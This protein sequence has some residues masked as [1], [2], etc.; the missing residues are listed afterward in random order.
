MQQQLSHQSPSVSVSKHTPSHIV[1][2]SQVGTEHPRSSYTRSHAPSQVSAQ[3][4]AS[5]ATDRPPE[6]NVPTVPS[7][8]SAIHQTPSARTPSIQKNPTIE[9]VPP[10][11]HSIHSRSISASDSRSTEPEQIRIHPPT[12]SPVNSRSGSVY[13]QSRTPSEGQNYGFSPSVVNAAGQPLPPPSTASASL[14][15]APTQNSRH[16]IQAPPSRHSQSHRSMVSYHEGPSSNLPGVGEEVEAEAEAQIRAQA[17]TPEASRSYVSTSAQTHGAANSSHTPHPPPNAQMASSTP[18]A[19]TTS[20]PPPHQL[21]DMYMYAYAYPTLVP[22]PQVQLH[23]NPPTLAQVY[24]H[25]QHTPPHAHHLHHPQHSYQPPTR[26]GYPVYPSHEQYPSY[27]GYPSQPQ[28]QSQPQTYAH[29]Y[30]NYANRATSPGVRKNLGGEYVLVDSLDAAEAQ[31]HENAIENAKIGS[32]KGSKGRSRG[33]SIGMGRTGRSESK[34]GSTETHGSGDKRGSEERKEKKERG[35]LFGVFGGH[36][37]S[38]SL[39]MDNGLQDLVNGNPYPTPVSPTASSHV[40]LSS[41][42]RD[43]AAG[44]DPPSIIYAPARHH[45]VTHY[46]PPKI[47][48]KPSSG[49]HNN[50]NNNESTEPIPIVVTPEETEEV[51]MENAEV[52]A[53]DFAY[54]PKPSPR[55]SLRPSPRPSPTVSHAPIPSSPIKSPASPSTEIGSVNMAGVGTIL[56]TAPPQNLSVGDQFHGSELGRSERGGR[57]DRSRSRASG[58][59]FSASAPPPMNANPGMMTM[60]SVGDGNGGN[61]GG[62]SMLSVASPIRSERSERS[63]RSRRNERRKQLPT[64]PRSATTSSVNGTGARHDGSSQYSGKPS[65]LGSGSVDN[66]NHFNNTAQQHHHHSQSDPNAYRHRS[67]FL[68]PPSSSVGTYDRGRVRERRS[69]VM[70]HT[71]V[72]SRELQRPMDP[73]QV[74]AILGR[75]RSVETS[76]SVSTYYV[77][78]KAGQKVQVIVSLV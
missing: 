13:P 30:N 36:S 69:Q 70:D 34:D 35:S 17:Q 42:T 3:H 52:A 62:G 12:A 16:S 66:Y 6:P 24:T 68:S 75:S 65:V 25:S 8:H 15:Y 18:V 38:R 26:G 27:T 31:A 76:S 1:T 61:G 50:N 10:S 77:L 64:P 21:T 41:P 4:P 67:E 29:E 7:A 14:S 56:S 20:L 74:E 48:Y 59:S 37:R 5:Q 72:R 22:Q 39:P 60:G 40:G 44:P 9:P 58:M 19:K 54:E 73:E 2:V 46:A 43:P 51:R 57:S 11:I 49:T 53:R 28:S 55:P 71:S 45:R 63:E 23:P 33:L 47:Y 78:S 32:G